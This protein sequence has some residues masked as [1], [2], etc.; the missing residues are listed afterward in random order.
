MTVPTIPDA[1]AR[2][3]GSAA[4]GAAWLE[5]LP[6]LVEGARERWG[7]T[8][9]DPFPSGAAGWTA[10]ARTADGADVVVKIVFPHDEAVGEAIALRLWCGNGGPELLDHDAEAWT[11]LLRHLRPGHGIEEDPALL[12]ARVENR[13]EIA[14][15]LLGRLQGASSDG[16]ELVRLADYTTNLADILRDRTQRHGPSLGADRGLLVEAA[17]LLEELPT[18]YTASGASLVHGDFNPGNILADDATGTRTWV[19]IDPKPMVGDPAY[20]PAPL[21]SQVAD[22][23][24][25]EDAV[26]L[27]RTRTRVVGG[28]SGLDPARV[29]AWAMARA[30]ES[31][32]WRA[33]QLGDRE[34]ALAELDQA[35]LWSRLAV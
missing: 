26:T 11:L 28:A 33:D 16:L 23:F 18:E 32:L 25:Q 17:N 7:L 13:L 8:L 4:D 22:P 30:A 12:E 15:E 24:R 20:D 21:V 34:G 10:P 3:V 14:G 29:A 2:Q 19:A 5:R 9:G 6:H 27:L 31:A 1:L 35:H